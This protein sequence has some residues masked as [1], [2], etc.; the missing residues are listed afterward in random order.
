MITKSIG[1]ENP[2]PSQSDADPDLNINI[3]RGLKEVRRPTVAPHPAAHTKKGFQIATKSSLGYNRPKTTE[4]HHITSHP[5]HGRVLGVWTT[6][7]IDATAKIGRN[8]VSKHQIQPEYG[9][10]QT[11]AGRDY[12]REMLIFPD[13]LTTSR[14]GNLTRLILTLA[15]CDDPFVAFDQRFS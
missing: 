11:D 3:N 8:P 9:D 13:Q 5:R 1:D 2:N 4:K 15:I 12:D 10:E 7:F 14:I 6:V